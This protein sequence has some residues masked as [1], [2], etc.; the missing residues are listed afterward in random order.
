M[1]M[2]SPAAQAQDILKI[3]G[4]MTTSSPATDWGKVCLNGVNMK[5]NEINAAAH[6]YLAIAAL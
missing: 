5:V 4:L 3:G 1:L 6:L 2:F